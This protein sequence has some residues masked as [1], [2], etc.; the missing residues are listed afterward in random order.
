L[1]V[2]ASPEPPS[3]IPAEPTAGAITERKSATDADMIVP[4]PDLLCVLAA[5]PV[6]SHQFE[7]RP[8]DGMDRIPVLNMK[9]VDPLTEDLRFVIGLDPKAQSCVQATQALL[10]LAENSFVHCQA[11][12][13]V[14][15]VATL[16]N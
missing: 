3:A 11:A 2:S 5:T 6:Q 4:Y 8:N 10:Q 14:K 7:R 15:M 1:L 9:E 12:A 16:P 13:F